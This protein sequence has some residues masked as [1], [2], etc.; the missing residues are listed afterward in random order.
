MTSYDENTEQWSSYSERFDYFVQANKIV[1]DIVVPIF[2]SAQRNN[3]ETSRSRKY[4][5]QHGFQKEG[6]A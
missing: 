4:N 2:Q 1:E 5:S 6:C 3:R